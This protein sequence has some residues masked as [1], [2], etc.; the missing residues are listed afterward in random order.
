MT[1][2]IYFGHPRADGVELESASV[3]P[4]EV[5]DEPRPVH[6]TAEQRAVWDRIVHRAAEELGPVKAEE[7][8]SGP[9]LRYEGPHGAFQMEYSGDSAYLEIPYWFSGDAALVVLAAAYRR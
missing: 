6:L 1:Y 9:L 8:P 7:H 2:D 5:D 4:E 3:E